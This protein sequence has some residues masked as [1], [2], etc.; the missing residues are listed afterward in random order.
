MTD[1]RLKQTNSGALAPDTNFTV[2]EASRWLTCAQPVE[3]RLLQQLGKDCS[4]LA[5]IRNA[6]WTLR[7]TPGKSWPNERAYPAQIIREVFEQ[8]P[9]T[10]PYIPKG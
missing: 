9:R 10:A 6:E 3:L 4:M 5:R 2:E 7:P 8:N 1:L